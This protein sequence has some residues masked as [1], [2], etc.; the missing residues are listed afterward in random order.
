[1][2]GLQL[3]MPVWLWTVVLGAAATMAAPCCAADVAPRAGA[4]REPANMPGRFQPV[5]AAPLAPGRFALRRLP[6]VTSSYAL[7]VSY[8]AP[9]APTSAAGAG[10]RGLGSGP[11]PTVL[12]VSLGEEIPV[13]SVES[14]IE[15][16]ELVGTSSV[17]QLRLEDVLAS[18][19]R[20]FPMLLVALAQRG[21]AAGDLLSAAGAFD[22]KLSGKAYSKSLGFYQYHENDWQL[23]RPTYWGG[24]VYAGYKLGVGFFPLWYGEDE[25][26]NGGEFR[27][28]FDTPILQDRRI[29]GR[30]AEIQK[31]EIARRAVEPG[32]QRQRI[33]VWRAAATAYWDWVAARLVLDANQ[34]LLELAEQRDQALGKRVEQGD[35]AEMARIENQ[36]LIAQRRLRVTAAERK[37]RQSAIKLSLFW[38]DANGWPLLVEPR[39]APAKFPAPAIPDAAATSQA[40]SLALARRPDLREI[41]WER[42][43][44]GV[45]LATG[46]NL[47]RPTLDAGL[48]ASQDVGAPDKPRR[49]KSPFEIQGGLYFGAPIERRMA[50]GK[51]RAAQA[52]LAQ[53]TAKQRFAA[54]KIV[55][56]VRDATV[57]WQTAYQQ[58]EQAAEGLSLV[59]Q[60]E[61]LERRKFDLGAS[62]LLFLN[63]RE[64]ATADAAIREIETVYAYYVA[65]ADFR[66]ATAADALVSA[67]AGHP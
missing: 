42:H 40:V 19:D 46:Q 8:V 13:P 48:Q 28:G 20:S 50:Q 17:P 43:R 55:A 63:L 12:A 60:V 44:L 9:R 23:D 62:N 47:L 22:V 14:R 64:Q 7:P 38:R 31:A 3:A 59:R 10:L 41:T 2:N 39:Q 25:T 45:E 56:E 57:A 29:D 16:L 54:D 36:G 34:S 6:P 21:I 35:L 30:R 58:V 1:M 18:V 15:E 26:N 53:L 4:A 33:D 27:L 52:K 66:A 65:V 61:Q 11:S 51:V 49:D 32:I 37:F 5:A 24:R 67:P